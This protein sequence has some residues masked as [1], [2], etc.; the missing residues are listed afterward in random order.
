VRVLENSALV[1]AAA[2][3]FVSCWQSTDVH[4]SGQVLDFAIGASKR[5]AFDA[6]IRNQKEGRILNLELIDDSPTTYD[7]KYKG[8][9][10]A[11]ADFQRVASSDHWHIALPDCNC[12]LRLVFRDGKLDRIDE[13]EWKGPTE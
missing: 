10:I 8:T 11:P 3:I 4:Q 6:A 2:F 1:L 7:E 13:G 9:P 5:Q 12:W